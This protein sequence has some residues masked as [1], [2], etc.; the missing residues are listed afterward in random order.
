MKNIFIKTKK[1]IL[2]ILL[3]SGSYFYSQVRIANSTANSSAAH[4]SAFIGASS[5]P[6]YNATSNVG[7]GYYFQ[8]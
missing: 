2:L 1:V 5:N 8:E 3:A 6:I 4:S 7:K